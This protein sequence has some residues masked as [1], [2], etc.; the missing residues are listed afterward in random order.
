MPRFNEIVI[1]EGQMAK[2]RALRAIDY[3]VSTDNLGI[4]QSTIMAV[5]RLS[6]S[7]WS[8]YIAKLNKQ[9]STHIVV[10]REL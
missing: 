8:A 7:K 3:E 2:I 4:V 1:Y 6:Y 5:N 9:I 10:K